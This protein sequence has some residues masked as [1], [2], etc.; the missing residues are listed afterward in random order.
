MLWLLATLAFGQ[1]D[2][3]EITWSPGDCAGWGDT[4]GI[5]PYGTRCLRGGIQ[6]ASRP[7]VDWDG[8][9]D[10][11]VLVNQRYRAWFTG[12][13]ALSPRLS[14][15]GTLPF[16]IH[17]AGDHPEAEAALGFGDMQVGLHHTLSTDPLMA[18]RLDAGIRVPTSKRETWLGEPRVRVRL[19]PVLQT[20]P[21]ER[22]SFVAQGA[23]E[24][25]VTT[26]AESSPLPDGP[27]LFG[28]LTWRGAWSDHWGTFAAIV[29]R[30]HLKGEDLNTGPTEAR[31]GVHLVSEELYL[32]AWVGRAIVRGVG[33]SELR[34]GISITFI[35]ETRPGMESPGQSN[36]RVDDE[37]L[38]IV[39]REPERNLDPLRADVGLRDAPD[40]PEIVELDEPD[41]AP[42]S[43]D[44]TLPSLLLDTLYFEV[45]TT[46]LVEESGP[47]FSA[48]ARNLL[49]RPDVGP[50]LLE[51]HAS[52]EGS[53]TYN[54]TLSLQRADAIYR[55]LIDR[56]VSP[57]RLVIRPLGEVVPEDTPD[58]RQNRRVEVRLVL[59]PAFADV[60]VHPFTGEDM[61]R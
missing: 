26:T 7:V 16:V 17:A 55:A 1:A 58:L 42:P 11:D 28:S 41:D 24:L 32:D 47:V 52:E 39:E 25:R 34:A 2:D 53:N 3:L 31:A 30:R 29:G 14:L 61:S 46:E 56:G 22:H 21:V 43:D 10:P 49:A 36:A 18:A 12:I 59:D 23:L 50:I 13:T 51:G 35:A 4:P 27:R 57:A 60:P 6:G 38:R 33:S 8:S 9:E 37:E 19:G 5:A 40:R 54:Y 20:T 48:L 15:S 45:G 44:G